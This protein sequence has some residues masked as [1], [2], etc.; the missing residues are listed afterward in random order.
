MRNLER[1]RQ[2]WRRPV[3]NLASAPPDI[4]ERLAR[5][6]AAEIRL[7]CGLAEDAAS[8]VRYPHSQ[9]RLLGAAERARQ[10]AQHLR[11]ALEGSGQPVADPA[12]RSGPIEPTVRDRLL[13]RVSD[14]SGM[15]EAYLM[16]AQAVERGDPGVAGLLYDLHRETAED[17]R[18]LIWTLAQLPWTAAKTTSHEA[19]PCEASESLIGYEIETRSGTKGLLMDAFGPGVNSEVGRLLETVEMSGEAR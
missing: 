8:L 2:W 1:A 16:D 7:A 17:R 9:V 3:A 18:D 19:I 5:H 11:Q 15:S 6:Y 14:L 13:T 4:A 10:R 12:T